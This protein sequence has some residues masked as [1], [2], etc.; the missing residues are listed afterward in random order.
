MENPVTFE[1]LTFITKLCTTYDIDIVIEGIENAAMQK[2]FTDMG[3]SYLQGYWFSK[4]LSLA[5]AS[6]YTTI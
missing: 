5:S 6:H 2:V 3:A 1:Y 4:P